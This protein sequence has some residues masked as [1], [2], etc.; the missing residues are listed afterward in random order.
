MKIIYLSNKKECLVDDQDYTF[1]NAIRWNY[2]QT[3][4][5]IKRFYN[6]PPGTV[7]H[8]KMHRFLLNIKDPRVQVDHIN[9]NKL[10]NRRSN[11]RL[12]NNAQNAAN[13]KKQRGS[14]VY[15]GVQWYMPSKKWRAVI[16]HS[17]KSYHLGHFDSETE[18]ARAY[19]KAAKEHFG[20]FARLNFGHGE[21]YK[22]GATEKIVRYLNGEN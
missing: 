22:P 7:K 15:K 20:E 14:S 13:K 16:T 10:D 3:G 11:L 19:D 18:A 2:S 9:G 8:V 1:L 5:A 12:S 17:Y 6:L 21:T 4:Y